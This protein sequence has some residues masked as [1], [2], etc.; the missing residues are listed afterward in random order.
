[1]RIQQIS[2]ALALNHSS[3][4]ATKLNREGQAVSSPTRQGPGAE[5]FHSLMP[6]LLLLMLLLLPLFFALLLMLLLLDF[7]P[8]LLLLVWG[9]AIR[10]P[11]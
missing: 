9:P 5:G 2:L 8:P 6:V 7:L 11:R 3:Q 4:K 10:A 1:M